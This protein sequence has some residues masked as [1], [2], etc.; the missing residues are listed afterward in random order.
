[1]SEAEPAPSPRGQRVLV[2][3]AR[4]PAPGRCK[5]R[6]GASIGAVSA[7]R[8]QRLLTAHT[9]VVAG[10]LAAAGRCSKLLAVEGLG[11][12]A[13]GRWGRGAGLE[14]VVLQGKGNLGV[15]MARQFHRAFRAGAHRVVL[16]GTDLPLLEGADL[17]AAFVALEHS[18]L[19]LGPATDG[20]YWLIGLRRPEPALFCGIDWG[21]S[22]VLDQTLHLARQ[23]RLEPTLLPLRSDLDRVGDLAPWHS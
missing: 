11:R 7:A 8:I 10:A 15:R 12:R 23:C 13:A 19:V 3:M 17:A 18:P 20:G 22:A 9:L 6:L 1:M 21:S 4:W 2:V 14:A 5:R 16:I